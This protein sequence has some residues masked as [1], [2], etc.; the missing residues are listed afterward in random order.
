MKL[1]V[2]HKTEILRA[3]IYIVETVHSDKISCIYIGVNGCEWHLEKRGSQK[4]SA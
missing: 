1:C 4:I 2:S 3:S